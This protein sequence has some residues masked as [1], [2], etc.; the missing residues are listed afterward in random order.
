VRSQWC[1]RL[2]RMNY[3]EVAFM[4]RIVLMVT[5]AIVMAVMMAVAGPALATIHPLANMECSNENASEVTQSQDPPG[6]TPGGP[7][8]SRA[9]VAQP[10]ISVVTAQGPNSPAFKTPPEPGPAEYC[11]AQN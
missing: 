7:D 1:N 6:L 4:K 3:K 10:V 11:P 2:Y 5:V 8:Q 9:T